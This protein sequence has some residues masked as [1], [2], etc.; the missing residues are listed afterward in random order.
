MIYLKIFIVIIYIIFL[1]YCT[2][3]SIDSTQ[4]LNKNFF[5]LIFLLISSIPII[6]IF[7]KKI[8]Y[9][10]FFSKIIISSASIVFGVALIITRHLRQINGQLFSVNFVLFLGIFLFSIGTYILLTTVISSKYR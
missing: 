8:V 5:L 9:N 6:D 2:L 4:Q 7:G 3:I 1:S 10:D